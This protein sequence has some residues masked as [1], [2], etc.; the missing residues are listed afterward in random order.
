MIFI[1][2]G[3]ILAE[4]VLLN[5]ESP[6]SPK[7]GDGLPTSIER[8]GHSAYIV[9]FEDCNKMMCCA[10]IINQQTVLTAAHCLQDVLVIHDVFITVGH[11]NFLKG[12]P[13]R[14]KAFK[15]HEKYNSRR[16]D[17]DIAL[18]TLAGTIKLDYTKYRI[19][20]SMSSPKEGAIGEIAGWGFIDV[21]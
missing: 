17:N 18:A 2:I 8:Y 9:M 11:E 3:L 14:M 21:S 10:S 12:E 5:S 15:I 7:I 6:I 13:Y 16:L 20:L 19:A 4:S 1:L